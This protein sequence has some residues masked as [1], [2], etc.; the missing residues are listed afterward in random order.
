M[1]TKIGLTW[2]QK[3]TNPKKQPKL[4]LGKRGAPTAHMGTLWG[5]NP[6]W[7]LW[8]SCELVMFRNRLVI[9]FWF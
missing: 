5:R 8:K 7:I 2:H 3:F 6:E 9:G 4:G 1:V